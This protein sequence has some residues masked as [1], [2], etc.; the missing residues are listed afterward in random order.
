V[1]SEVVPSNSPLPPNLDQEIVLTSFPTPATRPTTVGLQA[2]VLIAACSSSE[3]A[4]EINGRGCF[5]VA[6]I[7]LLEYCQVETLRY[8][9]VVLRMDIDSRQSPTC[10][11]FNRE[12]F[13]FTT[14]SPQPAWEIFIPVYKN[15]AMA[16]QPTTSGKL[17]C[18]IGLV[19]FM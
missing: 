18:T 5:T 8:C 11:G 1:R 9:D 6:L 7:K 17:F 4:W 13:A 12:R 15:V 10:E 2:H 3:L 19:L 16:N 14:K